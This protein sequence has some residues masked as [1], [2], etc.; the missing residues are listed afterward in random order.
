[1]NTVAVTITI[2]GGLAAIIVLIIPDFRDRV[3]AIELRRQYDWDH[4]RKR[5]AKARRRVWMLQTWIPYPRQDRAVWEPL[6]RSKRID[7]RI[8]LI[9]QEIVRYRLA[10]RRDKV[11]AGKAHL[12]NTPQLKLLVQDLAKA[13]ALSRLE[14]RRYRCLP[15]GPIYIIDNQV[16]FGLY[17][18][19]MDALSGP[20]FRCR[21]RSRLG[22]IILD[23]YEQVWDQSEV[24][25]AT[26]EAEPHIAQRT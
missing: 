6:L 19:H 17:Y 14:I 8:L 24:E 25:M 5:V 21:V 11:A 1:M 22:S 23:S 9:R 10:Y 20:A 7:F 12:E 18:S 15:F 2:I 3:A 13:G 26:R 16:Y 4:V